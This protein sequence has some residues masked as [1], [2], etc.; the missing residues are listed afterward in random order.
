MK[1]DTKERE[2]KKKGNSIF[3]I[4]DRMLFNQILPEVHITNSHTHKV[5]KCLTKGQ[6]DS[7][8]LVK[9]ICFLLTNPM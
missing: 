6:W 5:T 2:E 4:V 7:L 9:S 8:T 1:E 3:K